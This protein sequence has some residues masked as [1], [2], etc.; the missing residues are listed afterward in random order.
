MS[1]SRF[2]GLELLTHLQHGADLTTVL[3][4]EEDYSRAR[5]LFQDGDVIA[6]V[7]PALEQR[8]HARLDVLPEVDALCPLAQITVFELGAGAVEVEADWVEILDEAVDNPH[9]FVTTCHSEGQKS[10]CG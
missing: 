2:A 9:L 5:V 8:G 10:P 3:R 4:P 1:I 7:D 6:I